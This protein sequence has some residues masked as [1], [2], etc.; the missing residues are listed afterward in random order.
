MIKETKIQQININEIDL[1]IERSHK[2][3]NSDIYHKLE[4]SIKRNGQIQNIVITKVDNTYQILNGYYICKIMKEL[5][6]TQIWCNIIENDE[7][8]MFELDCSFKW[9]FIKV[10]KRI[11]HL[12][13]NRSS[14]EISYSTGMH[15]NEVNV[16]S[17]LLEYDFLR[18]KEKTFLDYNSS[19]KADFF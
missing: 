5:G 2:F 12:L 13:L 11:I 18:D 15:E 8:V 19:Q 4:N 7:L 9:D 1:S 3:F 16:F 14:K 10:A 6:Y 17:R